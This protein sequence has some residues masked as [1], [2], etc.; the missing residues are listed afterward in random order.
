MSRSK[1]PQGRQ[2]KC[3]VAICL[4]INPLAPAADWFRLDWL[5]IRSWN[6]FLCDKTLATSDSDAW[7]F[8]ADG[9][10]MC[11]MYQSIFFMCMGCHMKR[12]NTLNKISFS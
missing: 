5:D 12:G 3:D 10:A 1:S 7:R 9:G 8:L 2:G 11:V 4:R 6:L